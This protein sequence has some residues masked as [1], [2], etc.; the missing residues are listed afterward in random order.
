MSLYIWCIMLLEKFL[1]ILSYVLRFITKNPSTLGMLDGR[2]AMCPVATHFSKGNDT[3]FWNTIYLLFF[4]NIMQVNTTRTTKATYSPF[5]LFEKAYVQFCSFDFKS[6]SV[7]YWS[8]FDLSYGYFLHLFYITKCH[9]LRMYERAM[10][11][12][13]AFVIKEG[14]FR[15]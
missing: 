9:V 6:C 11:L 2:N 1:T 4:S 8:P 10:H 7:I 14:Q 12:P 3:S 5:R 15:S 13:R